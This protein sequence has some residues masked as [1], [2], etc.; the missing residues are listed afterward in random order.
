MSEIYPRETITEEFKQI[1]NQ[2]E[3]LDIE[4]IEKMI[5][6]GKDLRKDKLQNIYW[7]ITGENIHEDKPNKIIKEIENY[8]YNNSSN[9]K[10][11]LNEIVKDLTFP[12]DFS[13][14]KDVMTKI[15]KQDFDLNEQILNNSKLKQ[16]FYNLYRAR[17]LKA[18]QKDGQTLWDKFLN[19]LEILKE[20]DKNTYISEW[21]SKKNDKSIPHIEYFKNIIKESQI[22]ESDKSDEFEQFW[23]QMSCLSNGDIVLIDYKEE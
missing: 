4:E 2:H 11:E 12:V 19:A 9:L 5:E 1:S 16:D 6:K 18:L 22:D 15:Q 20:K 10:E 3:L 21:E 13:Q 14:I 23:Q 17:T 7:L 8:L